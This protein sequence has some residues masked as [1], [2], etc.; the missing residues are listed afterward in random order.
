MNYLNALT[1]SPFLSAFSKT[2]IDDLLTTD[3]IKIRHYKKDSILH[4]DGEFCDC[5]ELIV[6]G[7]ISIDRID[8]A[9]NLLTISDFGEGDILGGNIMF[10]SHP[11][12]LMMVT[13]TQDTV[14]LEFPK[15]VLFD[16]LTSKP[17]FLKA[18]LEFVSDLTTTLGNKIRNAI[19]LPLREKI[20]KY[21]NQESR[22]QASNIIVLRQ[23]KTALAE[24]L[25][26]QRSSLSRELKKM[27]DDGLVMVN[28]KKITLLSKI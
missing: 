12:Y 14:V 1:E 10:S 23:T 8:R 3:K 25:G 9:G 7:R 18:Y 4:F 2:E 22:L 27:Q 24:R 17:L 5:L 26:V 11:V 19:Q 6:E 15:E 28:Q 16:L 20:L 13:A 21:L